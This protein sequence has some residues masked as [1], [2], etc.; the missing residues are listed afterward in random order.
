M[1]DNNQ[2]INA[3]I[4]KLKTIDIGELLEKAQ[5]IKIED[6]RSVKWKD[7]SNSKL[8]FPIVGIL[9]AIGSSIW[10]FL[11]AYR[12]TNLIR[13]EAKLYK[14]ETTQLGSLKQSLNNSLLIK[15]NIKEKSDELNS[16]I[17]EKNSLINIPRLLNDSAVRA[18]INLMEIRPISKDSI[19]CFYSDEQRENINYFQRNLRRNNLSTSQSMFPEMEIK[20]SGKESQSTPIDH[21]Q[22]KPSNKR[23]RN[24]FSIPINEIDAQFTS[25]FYQLNIEATYL[26]SLNFIKNLQDYRVSIIPI[27]FEPKGL[28]LNRNSQISNSSESKI[29]NKL[30]IRLIIN[31]PTE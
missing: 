9:L 3:F 1:V 4:K 21:I 31:V 13:I 28:L 6:I 7:I 19:S 20:Q 24:I 5:T 27:C 29:R 14:N 12:K 15:K 18:K 25:N 10:I 23:L 2:S 26:K 16:F 17:I 11:P 30:N 8:F 22:F